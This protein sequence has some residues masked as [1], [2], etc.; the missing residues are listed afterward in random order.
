MVFLKYLILCLFLY[1]SHQKFIEI[2]SFTKDDFNLL[3]KI[4]KYSNEI[5]F[6]FKIADDK[7]NYIELLFGSSLRK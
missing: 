2:T 7:I 6:Q 1:A 4:S 3:Y 5:I